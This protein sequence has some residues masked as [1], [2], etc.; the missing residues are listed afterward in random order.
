MDTLTSGLRLR[1]PQRGLCISRLQEYACIVPLKYM[2]L[3]GVSSIGKT[4]I[5]SDR[6]LPALYL[7]LLHAPTTPMA[8]EYPGYPAGTCIPA[9]PPVGWLKSLVR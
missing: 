9:A 2:K 7:L 5:N 8:Y 3:V 6:C 1:L 4:A